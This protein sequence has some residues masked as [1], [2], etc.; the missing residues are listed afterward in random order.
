[1]LQNAIKEERDRCQAAFFLIFLD[2]DKQL[3]R[4]ILK[5]QSCQAR[6]P[7]FLK[8]LKVYDKQRGRYKKCRRE[9]YIIKKQKKQCLSQKEKLKKE[10]DKISF[11]LKKLEQI[12]KE[13]ERLRLKK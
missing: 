7:L 2:K 13:T 3:Y 6:Y 1:M 12:R 11:E 5:E 9:A 4:D 10:R 8:V